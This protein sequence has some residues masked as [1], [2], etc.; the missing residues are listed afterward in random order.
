MSKEQK[1]LEIE[2]TPGEEFTPGEDPKDDVS[3]DLTSAQILNK[4]EKLVDEKIELARTSQDDE[5]DEEEEEEEKPKSIGFFPV[6][7][8][9]TVIAAGIASIIIKNRPISHPNDME[10]QNDG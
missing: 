3:D 1:E 7:L 10:T 2:E 9:G 5:D 4:V 6:L 8:I